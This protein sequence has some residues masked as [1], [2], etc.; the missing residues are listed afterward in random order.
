MVLG[1]KRVLPGSLAHMPRAEVWRLR[2]D[3]PSTENLRL[4]GFVDLK[5]SPVSSRLPHG[6]LA[7]SL[8]NCD[9]R[10]GATQNWGAGTTVTAHGSCVPDIRMAASSCTGRLEPPASTSPFRGGLLLLPKSNF[11]RILCSWAIWKI[12]ALV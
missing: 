8:F 2:A 11:L 10:T 4:P 7:Q 3:H 9:S 12:L 1:S 5:R 6:S